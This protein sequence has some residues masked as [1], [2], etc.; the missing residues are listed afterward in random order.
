MTLTT[1][2]AFGANAITVPYPSVAGP[3]GEVSS[4]LTVPVAGGVPYDFTVTVHQA[5]G[6]PDPHNAGSV[7]YRIG[8]L[9]PGASQVELGYGQP[10]LEYQEPAPD[11]LYRWAVNVAPGETAA[12][13]VSVDPGALVV[14]P[15]VP[16]Q[17][18]TITYSV[19]DPSL[20][21]PPPII[22]GPVTAG[23]S[24]SSPHVINITNS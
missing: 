8:V 21:S 11:G 7:H 24:V 23:V 10:T 13:E 19:H 12:L 4:T 20:G 9:G 6:D 14:N 15:F 2:H 3:A 18:G 1:T 5:P 17:A 16:P 22:I